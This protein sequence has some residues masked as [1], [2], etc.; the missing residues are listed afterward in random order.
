MLRIT[1]PARERPGKRG[2]WQRVEKWWM[3]YGRVIKSSGRSNSDEPQ[4]LK[5]SRRD[6]RKTGRGAQ[7]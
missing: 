6:V 2:Q 4:A 5:Q 7:W 3:I 1:H